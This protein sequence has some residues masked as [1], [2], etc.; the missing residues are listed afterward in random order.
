MSG[1]ARL[2]NM[3]RV[4]D[5]RKKILF[6]L[7]IILIFRIGSHIP[8]PYVD[9][10]SVQQLSQ[11][12]RDNPNTG[13]LGLLN[14]FSGGALTADSGRSGSALRNSASTWMAIRPRL[15]CSSAE[16]TRT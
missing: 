8:V 10:E 13:V 12:A 1:L 2:K 14:V 6:T 3:F 9:F 16:V 7:F 15:T 5:L 4:P 11:A